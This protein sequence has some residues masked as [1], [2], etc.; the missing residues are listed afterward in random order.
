M[1][2]VIVDIETVGFNFESYDSKIQEYLLKYSETDEKKDDTKKKLSLFPLTGEIVA[3]GL[4]N[5]D[6]MRGTV[7]FQDKNSKTPKLEEGDIVYES[8]NEAEILEK[9]WDIV[10]TYDQVITFNGRGFDAPYLMLRSAIHKVRATKNLM[11]YRFDHKEHCDLMEQ[12]TFY[13]A[14]RKFSLDFYAKSFGIK[15]SKEE[16]IDG[17]MVGDFYEKGKFMD[18]ARY[19]F[20]DLVATKELYDYWDRYLRF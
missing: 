15:S 6:T 9:F 2:K 8:G 19:C 16:G 12:L 13:G 11:G 14:T 3:I 1:S 4:L 17:S 5:P 20:R 18:I 7:L 10:K